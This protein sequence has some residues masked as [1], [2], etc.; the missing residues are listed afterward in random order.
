[1]VHS[2]RRTLLSEEDSYDCSLFGEIPCS[3]VKYVHMHTYAFAY[4]CAI[5]IHVCI[6]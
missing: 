5:C 1:M 3:K 6:M 2:H 4:L